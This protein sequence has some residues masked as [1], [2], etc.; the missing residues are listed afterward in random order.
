MLGK[1]DGLTRIGNQLEEGL[2]GQAAR[3]RNA[4]MPLKIPDGVGGPDIHAAGESAAEEAEPREHSLRFHHKFCI[5]LG[6]VGKGAARALVAVKKD[7]LQQIFGGISG[8]RQAVIEFIGENSKPKAI[9]TSLK[10]D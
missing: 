8:Q 1:A 2:T 10:L 9:W 6:A 3:Q 5:E 4:T 7:A